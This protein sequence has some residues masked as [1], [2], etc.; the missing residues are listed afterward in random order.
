MAAGNDQLVTF[1]DLSGN[2]LQRFDYSKDDKVRDFTVAAFNPSGD[3]V[4]LGNF[5]R[6][7]VYNFNSKR[8]Q[9][10][11]I[12]CKIIKNYY[13][14]TAVCWKNDGSKLIT[15]NL[16]GS[17][18]LYEASMK[19]IRYKGKFEFNYVSPSQVVVLTL[20]T[21]KKSVVRSNNSQEI[22]KINIYQDRYVVAN[23]Y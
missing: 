10:E 2:F 17:L 11:E 19:K 8:G 12:A 4:V 18:D 13:T 1:Y 7:Y 5:N 15:G 22:S 20:A 16:C 6:F 23:T 9:W 3:T 21:G 14:V